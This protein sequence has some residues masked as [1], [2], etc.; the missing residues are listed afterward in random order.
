MSTP[1]HFGAGSCLA[2]RA[3][4]EVPPDEEEPKA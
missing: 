1:R 4:I 3:R 2:V